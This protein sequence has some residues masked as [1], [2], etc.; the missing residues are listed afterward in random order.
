M[1]KTRTNKNKPNPPKGSNKIEKIYYVVIALLVVILGGLVFFIFANQDDAIT[2]GDLDTAPDTEIV[3]DADEEETTEDDTDETEQPDEE[4]EEPADTD[5]TE[6][7]MK[8][9]SGSRR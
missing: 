6:N 4:A 8:N 7:T 5:E 1:K 2:E 3:D 9:G